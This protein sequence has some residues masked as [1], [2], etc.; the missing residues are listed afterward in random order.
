M[1]SNDLIFLTIES[2]GC[3][4]D[5]LDALKSRGTPE[6]MTS[7][8]EGSGLQTGP[9]SP[10]QRVTFSEFARL[11]QL[12]APVTENEMMGPRLGV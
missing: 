2:A 12:A 9:M 1:I 5:W 7:R 4:Q 6:K 3:V 8:L 11:Y 10:T